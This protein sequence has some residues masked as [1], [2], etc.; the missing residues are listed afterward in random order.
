MGEDGRAIALDMF[1]EPDAGAGLG[2]DRGERG[3]ADLKRIAPQVVAVQFD[4]VEGVEEYALVSALVTDEIERGNAVVIA[5]KGFAIDNAGGRAQPG[6]CLNDQRKAMGGVVARTAVEPHLRAGL[7]GNDSE[8]LVLISCSHWL[9]E[10]SLSVLVG[11][12]GAMN[13][14]GR[15]RIRNIMPT[16]RDYS[17]ASQSFMGH[18]VS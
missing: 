4:Q 11:T 17:R 6:Q 3:L 18:V 13:P 14:A 7:A 8:T 10:G 16:V 15:V 5:S 2:H 1:V 12:H 9:P